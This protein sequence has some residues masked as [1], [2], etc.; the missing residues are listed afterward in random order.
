MAT[1]L[2]RRLRFALGATVVGALVLIAVSLSLLR[3]LVGQA[4]ELRAEA[5]ALLSEALGRELSLGGLDAEWVGRHPRLVLEQVR[6]GGPGP[7]TGMQVDELEVEIDL[8]RSLRELTLRPASVGV[9]GLSAVAELAADGSLKLTRLGEA[10]MPQL[11]A[12]SGDLGALPARIHLRGGRLQLIDLASGRR[13][14]F[15]QLDLRLSNDGQHYV[16]GGYVRLPE[17]LGRAVRFRVESEGLPGDLGS[18][19]GRLYVDAQALDLDGLSP[20]LQHLVE[21]PRLRGQADAELWFDLQEGRLRDAAGRLAAARLAVRAEDGWRTVA[22][23]AG[24]RFHWAGDET[25]WQL[26]LND[27]DFISDHRVWP[28]GSALVRMSRREGERQLEAQAQYLRLDDIGVVLEHLPVLPQALR[29]KLA[30]A[31]PQGELTEPRLSLAWGEE[32]LRRYRVFG[33]FQNLAVQPLGRIP[34]A[35]GLSGWLRADEAGGRLALEGVRGSL[36]FEGLFREPLTFRRLRTDIVWRQEETGWR[37]EAPDIRLD[38][39]DA[40]VVAAGRL[41]LAPGQSPIVD[42]RAHLRDGNGANKSRYF[43]AG[44]MPAPL[45]AWLDRAIVGGEV[46]SADLVLYGPIQRFPFKEHDGIFDVQARVERGELAYLPDW[47]AIQD[48]QVDLRFFAQ[49]MEIRASHGR[50]FNARIEQARVWIDDLVRSELE[51]EGRLRAGGDDLLRFLRES[52]L[53]AAIR[54]ELASLSLSGVHAVSLKARVPLHGG[55]PRVNG[56]LALGEG[57]LRI[58]RWNLAVEGLSGNVHF[59]ERGVRSEVVRGRFR[60]QAVVASA[61]TEEGPEGPRIR[62]EMPLRASL[63]TLLG[64]EFDGVSGSGDWKLQALFPGFDARQAKAPSLWV[65]VSSELRGIAVDLPAPLAKLAEATRP[66][67]VELRLDRSRYTPLTVQYGDDVKAVLELSESG[68]VH[69]GAVRLGGEKPQL[70]ETPGVVV[71]GRLPRLDLDAWRQYLAGRMDAP[72]APEPKAGERPRADALALE[73]GEL[74][75]AGQEFRSTHLGLTRQGQAWRVSL[76]G[77]D[78]LGSLLLPKDPAQPVRADMQRLRLAFEPDDVAPGEPAVAATTPAA[79]IPPLDVTVAELFLKDQPLGRLE[80]NVSRSLTGMRIEHARLKGPVLE[81]TASGEWSRQEAQTQ[82]AVQLTSVNAGAA[83]A[84][85]GYTDAIRGGL[86]DANL[87]VSWPGGPGQFSLARISGKVD[88][89]LTNGQ[90][91][92]VDPGA[93]RLFGLLSIAALP[94][95][96]S[97]DFSDL[98]GR[99]FAF[100]QIEARLTLDNGDAFTRV[101]YMKGPA[102][103]VDLQGRI[104][105]GRRDYDQRVTVTP[106][107]S[108]ALPAV[109]AVT[110]GPVG[111][112]A[113]FITQKLLEKQLDKLIQFRYHVTGDWEQPVITPIDPPPTPEPPVATEVS[114]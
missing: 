88:L 63:Q 4:P 10:E 80:L 55:A 82:L 54:G 12:E 31:H 23:R 93:G 92:S 7:L 57:T 94:R 59:N 34:G 91:I 21:L 49:G 14:L 15:P 75:V 46:P 107:V 96:L 20:L 95:R 71:D 77:P 90:I 41:F 101:F 36:A 52:S 100:D 69:R 81:M 103:R 35:S 43:P 66:L 44:I 37:V 51:F 99:G 98:F 27:L 84:A 64:R 72:A 16:L 70:R 85:F 29:E 108:N 47:P 25:G 73:V 5:E 42:A 83:L 114:Q 87:A 45:V 22:A 18:A 105:L 68:G 33:Q 38:N 19:R 30:R 9:R 104:G 61:A 60:G 58:P 62:V 26:A 74:R 67:A 113:L 24:G 48:A 6:L 102:A 79:E 97:L 39:E 111:A 3:V 65:Q 112:V 32:G 56:V 13:Y 28:Q 106:H 78:A 1:R 17:T 53:S 76:D 86:A 11:T 2:F 40:S 110:G 50:L 8:L 89:S 109:G